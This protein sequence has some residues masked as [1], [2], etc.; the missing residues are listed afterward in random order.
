MKSFRQAIAPLYLFA[1]IVLGGS[2]QGIFSN[3][4]LQLSG[5]AILCWA[6]LARTPV[7]DSRPARQLEW[8]AA[9]AVALILVQLIPLPPVIWSHLPGR[10]FV[11]DGFRLLGQPLPWMPLSL[12]PEDTIATAMALLPPLAMLA[13]ILRLGAYRDDWMVIALLLAASISVAFGVLQIRGSGEEHYFYAYNSWRT[14]PGLFA[15]VNHMATL[16]L[17]GFP[18]LVALAARR[19]RKQ[20]KANDRLLTVTLAGGVA[21]ILG[22]GAAINHSTALLIIGAP[23]LGAAALQ[24]IPA[25]RVRLGRLAAM[26]GVL[27]FIGIAALAIMVSAGVSASDRTSVTMRADI[28]S[29]TAKAIGEHG[30]AGSGIGTFPKVYPLYENPAGVDRTYINHAHDD[31]LEI[32]LEAGIPGVILMLLF[33]GWWG[34]R[35]FAIWRSPDAAEMARAACIASAAILLHSMVDYPMRTAAIAT[36]MAM[37][38]GLMADPAKRRHQARV[39]D[40]RPSRHLTL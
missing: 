22:L 15:N 34:S 10:Q 4:A 6:F 39:S 24:L 33:I 30:V 36:C 18:F 23:V 19:W 25:G 29:H 31:Y 1:C 11:I 3:L 37:A 16:L 2:A 27:L 13:L 26:L 28:W 38:L 9:A 20:A 8:I 21:L 32:A 17:V 40:L 35:A 7:K 12:A 14:A 5:V